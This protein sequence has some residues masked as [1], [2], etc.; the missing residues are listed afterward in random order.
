M[1]TPTHAGASCVP[2]QIDAALIKPQMSCDLLVM[3]CY[4][5]KQ[6]DKSQEVPD[7]YRTISVGKMSLD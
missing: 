7:C 6:H 5:S 1:Y 4:L 3:T 2:W